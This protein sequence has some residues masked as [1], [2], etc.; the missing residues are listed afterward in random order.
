MNSRDGNTAIL[1]IVRFYSA[2]LCRADWHA[3]AGR[4]TVQPDSPNSA[5][6][7]GGDLAAAE[8]AFG[9]PDEGW[10]DLSTGINPT[11]YPVAEFP[12][13]LWRKLPARRLHDAV[14]ASLRG[15]LGLASSRAVIAAPGTQALIQ[16][17]PYLRTSSRVT[18]W[19]PTY[20]EHAYCWQ[21][22]G[23]SVRTIARALPAGEADACFAALTAEVRQGDVDVV[24]VVN[25]NNPDGI[26]HDP[27]RLEELRGLLAARGGW[28][29][30]DEAFADAVPEI[31]LAG[32]AR[33]EGLIVLRSFGKFFGL[34]GLRLGFA[35]GDVALVERLSRA[36]GPWAVSGPALALAAQAYADRDWIAATRAQLVLEH[37][38]LADLLVEHGFRPKGQVPLFTLLPTPDA[39]EIYAFFAR[40]GIL[41]RLFSEGA[42][43]LHALRIGL[44]GEGGLRRFAAALKELPPALLRH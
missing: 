36:L 11:S 32:A 38:Q 44:P 17:L 30:V 3:N 40:R 5:P 26:C 14:F 24:V 21:Q 23:H 12:L 41:L 29:I 27:T 31:S 25:P 4:K 34:A 22:A 8:G 28:L 13:D 18:V 2:D 1:K 42:P 19:T 7:H 6:P 10:L 33:T 43:P 35:L 15:Y 16:W 37:G 39:G 9:R 20:A